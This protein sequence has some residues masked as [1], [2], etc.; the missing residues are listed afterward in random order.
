MKFMGVARVIIFF[1]M[2]NVC[3]STKNFTML[4]SNENNFDLRVVIKLLEGSVQLFS[5]FDGKTI[6][7]LGAI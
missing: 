2:F 6:Q 1:H 4:A 7:I 5:H 3:S